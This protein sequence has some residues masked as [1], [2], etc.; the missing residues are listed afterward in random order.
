MFPRLFRRV[1]YTDVCFLCL[2][3]RAGMAGGKLAVARQYSIAASRSAGITKSAA[4]TAP[5]S[6][7]SQGC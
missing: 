5:M 4:S 6:P 1:V 3:N 7:L 2:E